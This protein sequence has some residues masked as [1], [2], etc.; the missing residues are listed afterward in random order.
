MAPRRI[1]SVFDSRWAGV[2]QKAEGSPSWL[3]C[4]TNSEYLQT[5]KL[6]SEKVFQTKL[7]QDKSIIRVPPK[8]LQVFLRSAFIALRTFPHPQICQIT[9]MLSHNKPQSKIFWTKAEFHTEVSGKTD[10]FKPSL[11]DVNWSSSILW[12]VFC[13]LCKSYRLSSSHMTCS[14]W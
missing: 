4:A 10:L 1:D 7:R 8:V 5:V 9:W 6:S 3:L 14:L 11:F 13:C 2:L 12:I